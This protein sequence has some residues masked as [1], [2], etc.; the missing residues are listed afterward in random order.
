[1]GFIIDCYPINS[2]LAY[3]NNN[4]S[5]LIENI[6]FCNKFTLAIELVIDYIFSNHLI[7][8]DLINTRKMINKII[9]DRH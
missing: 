8:F 1:M 9:I 4:V 5:M 3:A 6:M 2:S 7:T